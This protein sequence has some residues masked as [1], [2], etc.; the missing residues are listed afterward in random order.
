[1]LKLLYMADL[2]Y[3]ELSYR[4]IG[5][6]YKVHTALGNKYQE[7]YYQR[8]VALGLQE[9]SLHFIKELAVDL[10]FNGEKIGKYYLDFLV[11]EKIIVE[12]KT[13]P[14]FTRE[15][16]KQIMAYLKAKKI[17]IGYTCKFQR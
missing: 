11:E 16:F 17:K 5:V 9:E 6:L 8:A 1:M 7:R 3:P 15:H 4:I 12:L 13:E 10:S 2:V 14:R